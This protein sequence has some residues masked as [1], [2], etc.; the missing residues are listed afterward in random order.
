M[1]GETERVATCLGPLPSGW[2]LATV[3]DIVGWDGIFVDGDWVESKDQ[4]AKG[5]ARLVQLADIGDGVYRNKSNR[6]L[7]LRKATELKCT[8][9]EA[10]DLLVARMPDPLG[11]AS[12]F[13]G[14]PKPSVTA[15]DVC[16]IRTGENGANTKWLMYLLNSPQFRTA[17]MSLQ[18]GTTRKRIARSN[19]AKLEFPLPPLPEQHRI[20]AKIEELFTRLDAG[21]EA[22]KKVRAQ[23]KAYRQAVLRDAFN[24]R[25][26]AEWREAH[27]GE[28]EPA[29]VLL[30]QIK[31][32][33][34]K[35]F[36]RGTG[37]RAPTIMET[38]DLPQLPEGWVW[39][40]VGEVAQVIMGQS[41]PG[42]SYNQRGIGVPLV[43]GPV[44]FGP[45][46]FSRTIKSK[47]TTVPKKMCREND[48]VLCVRGSTTGRMNVAGFDACIGRGVAAIRAFACQPYLNFFVHSVQRRIYELGTGSTFP[49]V[50]VDMVQSF[51]I[52]LPPL[53]EQHKIVEEIE[54]RFSVAEEIENTV[55]QSLK[56]AERLRQSILKRAFGGK[57]VPQDPSDEPAE[58][59]MGRI[60]TE[61]AARE[62][63]TK[64]A[65]KVRRE[66]TATQK[67]LI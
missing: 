58:R 34:G 14:D 52:P 20:V 28:L 4:D 59:L 67:S 30:E 50:T 27:G 19:L 66:T 39:T 17:I 37:P 26:T 46:P 8:F 2:A 47:F 56:Q 64:P 38:T 65:R 53:P 29:S 13:P 54:R 15:V 36:G 21:V 35:T 6:F 11:R 44:E 61:K 16:I 43:K 63:E 32:E 60:K 18:S 57:L 49:N 31:A 25:L 48:L 3:S 55:G 24:G 40:R 7:T 9:L 22:L 41:P 1:S 10:G 12:I 45:N 62:L 51:D 42:D 33:R 5:D 23:L